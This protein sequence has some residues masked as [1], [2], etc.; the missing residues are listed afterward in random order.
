MISQYST[1]L[2]VSVLILLSITL[3]FGACG[4]GSGPV[5]REFDLRISDRSLNLDPAVM[6]VG[7]GDTVILNI[8]SD[9]PGR[10]HLHGYDIERQVGPGKAT[11]MEFTADATGKYPITFHPT[12]GPEEHQE[13]DEDGESH[14]EEEADEV[15]LGAL[16]VNPR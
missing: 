3:A 2:V 11:S 8:A 9:E 4:A 15:S 14:D 1:R 13:T 12:D 6:K 16:V 7:Q 10:F 5:E